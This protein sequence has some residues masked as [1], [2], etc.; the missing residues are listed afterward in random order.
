MTVWI[1]RSA[2]CGYRSPIAATSAAPTACP[3]ATTVPGT[4]SSR[5]SEQLTVE[6]IVRLAGVFI[7]LGVTKIRL[8]GGEPLLRP[9]LAQIV[10]R[11]G[12]LGISDLALTTNGALLRAGRAPSRDA[13]LHRVTVSLD[14]LDPAVFARDERSRRCTSSHVLDGIAAARAAGLHPIKLNCVV[15][16]GVNETSILSWLISPAPVT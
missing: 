7:S 4:G 15:R 8:T 10:R 16:R 3:G 9:D 11:L 5:G 1:G 2:T 13:G 12:S 6:E 14:S